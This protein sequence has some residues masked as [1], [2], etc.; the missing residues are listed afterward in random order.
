MSNKLLLIK[1]GKIITSYGIFD[2]TDIL[3]DNGKIKAI[4]KNISNDGSDVI[5]ANGMF[6]F[7]GVVDIHV[8][9]YGTGDI[10]EGTKEALLGGVT[11]VIDM[12]PTEPQIMDETSFNKKIND[13]ESN[14]SVDF[15][16]CAGE[17]YYDKH[18]E[19]IKK[20]QEL[21]AAYFKIFMPGPP[22]VTDDVIYKSL[23][24]A[25][26]S[27]ATIAIHAENMDIVNLFIERVK[28]SGRKNPIA[29]F[30]SRPK[31]A[32]ITAIQNSIVYAKVT[33]AHAHICHLTSAEAV[34]L[35]SNAQK[36]DI[37]VT[38]ETCPHYLVFTEE[39]I[40]DKGPS[41][42]M[43]PPIRKKSD[44]ERLWRGIERGIINVITTDHCSF[45]KSEKDKWKN[46]IWGA[47]SGI[48]GLQISFPVMYTE[49][50]KRG[51]PLTRLVQVM[52]T[53]PARIFHLGHRKGDIRIG[54]DADIIIFNPNR[55]WIVSDET[56]HGESD[57]RAYYGK[58]LEGTIE[59][60]VIRGEVALQDREITIKKGFGSFI[61]A[62]YLD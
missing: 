53:Y 51:L 54:M 30:E 40:N 44:Q 46:D 31:I 25:V 33:N 7:P 29:H 16:L 14:T 27:G 49:F 22:A 61:K 4:G 37:K 42:K 11:T 60:V 62:E 38:A 2:N 47:P 9:I 56:I 58:R 10:Y 34:D 19:N 26:K 28:K 1:N 48:P 52:S 12:P 45:T 18:I 32:E 23:E 15:G 5:D 6:V 43:I 39:D 41:L 20:L 50:L 8:H 17:I 59:T 3:I 57:Y 35:I 55:K 24:S 36:E 13:F 21:G